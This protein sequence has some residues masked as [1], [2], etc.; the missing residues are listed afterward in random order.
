MNIF[1]KQKQSTHPRKFFANRHKNYETEPMEEAPFNWEEE[2]E[3]LMEG[4]PD[5]QALDQ[6]IFDTN[7]LQAVP[8]QQDNLDTFPPPPSP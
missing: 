1:L 8:R 4:F 3:D 6:I 5:P 7:G 2:L